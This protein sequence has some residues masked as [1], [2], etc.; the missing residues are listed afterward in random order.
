MRIE[1]L[2]DH[3][4]E[5]YEQ[6]MKAIDDNA[7]R[8][9]K[10][11][12]RLERAAVELR[13]A[14]RRKGLL[15]RLF[16]IRSAEERRIQKAAESA[17]RAIAEAQE[18]HLVLQRRRLQTA[19]GLKGEERFRSR[20][21]RLGEE[22]TYIAGYKN[23]AGE[24]DA[25]LIGPRSVWAVEV[26]SH[27]AHLHV[28]G[29]RWWFEKYDQYGNAVETGRAVD[30]GGRNW[31]RQVSDPARRLESWL[32]R[33]GHRV[34]IR[35]AVV[36]TNHR[37]SLGAIRNQGVDLITCDPFELVYSK[38]FDGPALAEAER[39][40]IAALIERD[41]RH[42]RRRRAKTRAAGGKARGKSR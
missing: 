13:E 36:L 40:A 33:N 37:A 28:D 22:W 35:T 3:V 9:A 4:G 30:G 41:H 26:K 18:R 32:A 19:G 11:R 15:R 25:V 7:L 23:R 2:S 21:S 1:V 39:D 27:R 6:I 42:H 17:E 16:R 20:L 34:R 38:R 5:Q 10:R 8:L 24:I 31:G 29:E 12:R 14:R